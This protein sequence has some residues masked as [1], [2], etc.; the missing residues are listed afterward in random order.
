MSEIISDNERTHSLADVI[1]INTHRPGSGMDYADETRVIRQYKQPQTI[2]VW[3][4]GG[5]PRP[6]GGFGIWGGG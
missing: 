1:V 6:L 4:R 2:T 5:V 3:Y